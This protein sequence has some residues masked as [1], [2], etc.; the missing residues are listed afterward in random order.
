M[1]I[2]NKILIMGVVIAVTGGL[3]AYAANITK[4]SSKFIKHFKDCEPYQET[5]TSTYEGNEFTTNR[6]I[7]GWSNGLCKY[8]AIV[9]TTDEMYRLDCRFS[10][11]QIDDLY[12]SMKDKSKEITTYGLETFVEQTDEKTGKTKYVSKGI[13]A[14]KGNKAFITWAKYENNPYFCKPEKLK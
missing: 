10:A 6:K 5:I 2:V 11:I 7:H 3:C 8:E 1:K 12:E 4:F 9:K 14:I 13:T